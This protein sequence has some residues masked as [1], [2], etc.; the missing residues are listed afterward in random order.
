MSELAPERI[1]AAAGIAADIAGA[2]TRAAAPAGGGTDT[3]GDGLT[4]TVRTMVDLGAGPGFIAR[5]VSELL[6]RATLY[7]LDVAP[8]LVEYMRT[9]LSEEEVR[10]II[11]QVS[12][13]ATIDLEDDTVDFLLM[14][15]VYHELEDASR[16]LAE[17]LRV[18]RA[19]GIMLVIDWAKGAGSGGPP[20]HHRVPVEVL[21]S[22]MREA[23]FSEVGRRS[24][25]SRH[26]AVRGLA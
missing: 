14:V 15:D 10:R 19:G 22:E 25:F 21:E 23:G 18:L 1:L 8:E 16:L 11:P 12:A 9:E 5:G 7:A 26:H 2:G 4:A 24:G 6:P 13:E 3:A 20:D 17:A